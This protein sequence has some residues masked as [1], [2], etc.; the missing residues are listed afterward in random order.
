MQRCSHDSKSAAHLWSHMED[1]HKG[2]MPMPWP[3]TAILIFVVPFVNCAWEWE[4]KREVNQSE[5]ILATG[6]TTASWDTIT[7]S[8]KGPKDFW[9]RTEHRQIKYSALQIG[10]LVLILQAP[11]TDY[12][13]QCPPTVGRRIF[14]TPLTLDLTRWLNLANEMLVEAMW[15]KGLHVLHNW[16]RCLCS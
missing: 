15:A 7:V 14:P 9:T 8:Y 10:S 2:G 4:G 5:S 1:F 13:P 11:V 3:Q 6:E 12:T 16:T